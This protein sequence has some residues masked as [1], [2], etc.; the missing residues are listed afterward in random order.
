MRALITALALIGMLAASV[1]RAGDFGSDMAAIDVAAR[2]G[3]LAALENLE[4]RLVGIAP[5][6]RHGYL[7]YS[8]SILRESAGQRNAAE[9]DLD[10]SIEVLRGLVA[11][12]PESAEAWALLSCVY[13]MK[14]GH[15]PFQGPFLGPKASRALNEAMRLAPDN[16]RVALVKGISLYHTP[17]MF[18]GDRQASIDWFSEAIERFSVDPGG[19]IRWGH[20]DAYIWR[21]LAH[22][23]FEDD[24][25]AL[26]DLDAALSIEP[27][28]AWARSLRQQLTSLES[29]EENAGG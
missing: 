13:G 7:Y 17:R 28:E 12:Q 22:H 21:A 24:V 19:D 25:R 5:D 8:L 3:D 23:H 15:S 16:P 29:N 10:R 14:I 20:S 18:G 1:A 26:A 27:D 9:A 2:H 6:Y 4:G 11:A